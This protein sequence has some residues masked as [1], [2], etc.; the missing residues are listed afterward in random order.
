MTFFLLIAAVTKRLKG[1][2][3][4]L[5]FFPRRHALENYSL[6]VYFLRTFTNLLIFF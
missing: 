3:S 6:V 1:K 4:S 2:N 5:I